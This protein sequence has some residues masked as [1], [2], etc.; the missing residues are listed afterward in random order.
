MLRTPPALPSAWN[1]SRKG[2]QHSAMEL[3]PQ[4]S[5]TSS[6]TLWLQVMFS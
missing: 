5:A 2:V 1:P 6:Y 4:L 3:R